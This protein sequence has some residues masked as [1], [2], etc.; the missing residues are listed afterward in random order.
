MAKGDRIFIGMYCGDCKQRN[1]TTTK[2]RRNTEGR[3]SL[4]K[5]CRHCRQHTEHKEG[6]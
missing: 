6:K 3:L 4:R 5:F 1:Y 2:N